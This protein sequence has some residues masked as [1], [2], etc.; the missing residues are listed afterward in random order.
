M[1][2]DEYT[3]WRSLNLPLLGL[4]PP[5]GPES[6]HL[7]ASTPSSSRTVTPST[8]TS[9]RPPYPW[10]RAAH[11]SPAAT[12]G[13]SPVRSTSRA[14]LPRSPRRT[15]DSR[16]STRWRG[17]AQRSPFASL[18]H[19]SANAPATNATPRAEMP[20]TPF[21]EAPAVQAL[22]LRAASSNAGPSQASGCAATDRD[23]WSHGGSRL[24]T[25]QSKAKDETPVRPHEAARD[26]RI[27]AGVAQPSTVPCAV[28]SPLAGEAMCAFRALRRKRAMQTEQAAVTTDTGTAEAKERARGDVTPGAKRKL[29]DG[30]G[31]A[32]SREVVEGSAR[33]MEVATHHV[34]TPRVTHTRC[35]PFP[36][37]RPP[38]TLAMPMPPP[39]RARHHD[40]PNVHS[41]FPR[42]MASASARGPTA[43]AVAAA[44]ASHGGAPVAW[45][46]EEHAGGPGAGS[47]AEDVEMADAMDDDA[48]PPAAQP[49]AEWKER[50]NGDSKGVGVG[51]GW[52]QGADDSS[53]AGG[54]GAAATGAVVPWRSEAAGPGG[55]GT[56]S[57]DARC[58][59]VREEEGGVWLNGRWY[60]KVKVAGKGGS[61]EVFKVVARDGQE[62]ALKRIRAEGGA[63]EEFKQEI[64][65]LTRL[66]GHRGIIHLFDS[67]VCE[68]E[69]AI[70]LLLEFGE[71]D[72][73]KKLAK[74][75][76]E[77]D[78]PHAAPTVLATGCKIDE[79]VL[80][81]FWRDML[82]A[83]ETI[84]AARIVHADLKPA[85]F[86]IIE[87]DLKLI[88]FGIA[89]DIPNH[90]AHISRH[91]CAG[92]VSYMSPESIMG[93]DTD[94]DGEGATKP[95][96]KM[97]RA[98]DIWSLGCILYLMV[99][100]R[101]PF[102][103]IPGWGKLK[104]ICDESCVID[105]PP[106]ANPHL[107]DTMKRCL[108]ILAQVAKAA[109]SNPAAIGLATQ[110]ILKQLASGKAEGLDIQE[111]FRA[112]GA[113]TPP[114]A[115][116]APPPKAP[117]P[118][119]PP[120]KKAP[121]PPPPPP[122][123]PGGKAAPLL[124]KKGV[125]PK[126]GGPA[127]PAPGDLAAAAAAAARRRAEGGGVR[128]RPLPEKKDEGAGNMPTLRS[129]LRRGGG[130]PGGRGGLSTDQLQAAIETSKARLKPVRRNNDG[131]AEKK[132]G[133]E[134][135]EKNSAVPWEGILKKG[136]E[137]RK[138]AN[139]DDDDT[140]VWE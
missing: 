60:S 129:G 88:D 68:G 134:G 79:T 10:T 48:T 111:I 138:K 67:A 123:K 96:V 44:G 76:R 110:E 13:S 139:K 17:L 130:G 124:I 58:G 34:R 113:F 73:A 14:M 15:D 122:G 75:H 20:A 19:P 45:Q 100:G 8:G 41:P 108:D 92:T 22:P 120:P 39:K 107:L 66:R 114:A 37:S 77:A 42:A 97:G 53:G 103:H 81:H 105:F 6:L 25:P 80:R 7:T 63:M 106:L 33:K 85:N 26:A 140:T 52:K 121:P 109:G 112:A 24:V 128:M 72:L 18:P 35:S 93:Q 104:A 50:E 133:K 78:L 49:H 16:G 9:A 71:I 40:Q 61:S 57:A 36:V 125:K 11:A 89:K 31:S 3:W 30:C 28:K 99:Y 4:T 98:A 56:G 47:E 29:D 70:Y 101:T 64:S 38:G 54:G 86:L 119:P 131:T 12:P 27:Q 87:G 55:E 32:G 43:P 91:G 118:P 90:T 135:G 1:G 62:F 51:A 102:Q 84:H 83:V 117:P 65:I 126:A 116:P 46:R 74:L 137:G 23:A 95:T 69:Q 21:A 115:P 59:A 5:Q 82:R 132:E 127:G 136:L 2:E 94:A